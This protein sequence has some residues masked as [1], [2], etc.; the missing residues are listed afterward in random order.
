LSVIATGFAA[1]I[2]ADTVFALVVFDTGNTLTIDAR[3][4]RRATV[5]LGAIF[6]GPAADTGVIFADAVGT[7]VI[8][9]TFDVGADALGTGLLRATAFVVLTG[10]PTYVFDAGTVLTAVGVGPALYAGILEADFV[11]DTVVIL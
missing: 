3:A 7:L 8:V 2:D 5:S 11:A 1:I 9:P 10:D 4:G 6:Y